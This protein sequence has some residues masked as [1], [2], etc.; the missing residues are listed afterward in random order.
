MSIL[1]IS[2]FS[3]PEAEFQKYYDVNTEY[4]KLYILYCIRF[5]L[6]GL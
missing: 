2:K 6:K 3:L 1:S 4:R 5:S